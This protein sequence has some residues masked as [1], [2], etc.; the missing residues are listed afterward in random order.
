M[1]ATEGFVDK[2]SFDTIRERLSVSAEKTYSV[3]RLVRPKLHCITL[4]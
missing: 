1:L 3:R 2:K 4:Y